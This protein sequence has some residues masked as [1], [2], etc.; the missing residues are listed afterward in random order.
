MW[1]EITYD[2]TVEEQWAIVGKGLVG[3]IVGWIVVALIL[4]AATYL[5]FWSVT[6]LGG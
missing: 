5:E 1:E 3:L 2:L 4:G 6:H